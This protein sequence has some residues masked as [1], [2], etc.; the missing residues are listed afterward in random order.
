M[1]HSRPTICQHLQT[2]DPLR[3][4][5]P[6]TRSIIQTLSRRS[7]TMLRADTLC[8]PLSLLPLHLP[9][10]LHLHRISISL[11]REPLITPTTLP[12]FHTILLIHCITLIHTTRIPLKIQ[13]F[14]TLITLCHHHLL[15]R[16]HRRRIP[17]IPT[18]ILIL[19]ITIRHLIIHTS[20]H[21]T[22]QTIPKSHLLIQS[23][24]QCCQTVNPLRSNQTHSKNHLLNTIRSFCPLFPSTN[25][26]RSATRNLA[27]IH[28]CALKHGK[29]SSPPLIGSKVC[30]S[31]SLSPSLETLSLSLNPLTLAI[32]VRSFDPWKF[33]IDGKH[34]SDVR[35][36]FSFPLFM[37]LITL[38]HSLTHS[39]VC[40]FVCFPG[41]KTDRI[42]VCCSSS[43]RSSS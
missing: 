22:C 38:T 24:Q 5:T 1:K 43:Q 37:P 7:N 8:H 27:G 6:T 21:L 26:T 3:P 4:P 16:R 18:T 28:E 23:L 39:F 15:L 9:L 41:E 32:E 17:T 36:F 25:H 10:H 12:I 33:Q 34:P 29:F 2:S 35:F 13:L 14:I 19:P 31:L 40:L 20:Q 30:F 11:F 42:D